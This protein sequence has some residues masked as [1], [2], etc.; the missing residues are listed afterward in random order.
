MCSPD[1]GLYPSQLG[2]H[3]GQPFTP[4]IPSHTSNP[5]SLHT[6]IPRTDI[7]SRNGLTSPP[8]IKRLK[9]E[10]ESPPDRPLLGLPAHQHHDVHDIFVLPPPTRPLHAAEYAAAYLSAA[11]PAH[12]SSAAF[13]ARPPRAAAPFDHFD[14]SSVPSHLVAVT[15]LHPPPPLPRLTPPQPHNSNVF[16]HLL[17]QFNCLPNDLFL[18]CQT[19]PRFSFCLRKPTDTYNWT[20]GEP[21]PW[22]PVATNHNTLATLSI[23]MMQHADDKHYRAKVK[24]SESHMELFHPASSDGTSPPFVSPAIGGDAPAARTVAA[25]ES[26]N[27]WRMDGGVVSVCLDRVDDRT[28]PAG[29]LL[30]HEHTKKSNIVVSSTGSGGCPAPQCAAHLSYCLT[31]EAQY[32]SLHCSTDDGG[33]SLQEQIVSCLDIVV[34]EP[35]RKQLR[36]SRS[37][38]LHGLVHCDV[39]VHSRPLTTAEMSAWHGQQHKRP[40][41]DA[42][43]ANP[44]AGLRF[45]E[46]IDIWDALQ[47]VVNEDR[48]AAHKLYL[49]FRARI[50]DHNAQPMHD[51]TTHPRAASIVQML[52]ILS[53]F[54]WQEAEV[55]IRAI[56]TTTEDE[57][58][59]RDPLHNNSRLAE[60]AALQ[61]LERFFVVFCMQRRGGDWDLLT[62]DNHYATLCQLLHLPIASRIRHHSNGCVPLSSTMVAKAISLHVLHSPAFIAL[63]EYWRCHIYF[64]L[65][66]CY[67]D[68]GLLEGL[69]HV[70]TRAHLKLSKQYFELSR[71]LSVDCAQRCSVLRCHA[72]VCSMHEQGVVVQRYLSLPHD[73]GRLDDV[74]AE[75]EFVSLKLCLLKR[76]FRD[77][78]FLF[79]NCAA[80]LVVCQ[81]LLARFRGGGGVQPLD[82][83]VHSAF[84]RYFDDAWQSPHMQMVILVYEMQLYA[85]LG[86]WQ[87]MWRRSVAVNLGCSEA[88]DAGNIELRLSP[89]TQS[90]WYSIYRSLL[91]QIP[92][93]L[94]Y[95]D[96][97]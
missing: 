84:E 86:A 85:F 82:E 90:S 24:S 72:S 17:L 32:D 74:I 92:S 35:N 50:A 28:S 76:Q 65:A 48:D 26:A 60:L 69:D 31:I 40:A 71:L 95:I 52:H 59:R 73:G 78:S 89:L 49:D 3:F 91:R 22:P 46:S 68:S 16:I 44:R 20:A 37:L 18:P 25:S 13:L 45:T 80:L 63:D 19:A 14:H 87:A 62:R 77:G 11:F 51:S 34:H 8:P 39:Q 36:P 38:G 88:V 47:L 21:S 67:L 75:L 1:Y 7:L 70:T 57:L 64:E 4:S 66:L 10:V 94:A 43:L 96:I 33:V 83:R 54:N 61:R 97:Q 55:K 81:S 15:P 12:I 79:L 93:S 30:L 42:A 23:F 29:L 58:V 2:E 6:V 9:R 5:P 27:S 41:T 53:V 56:H